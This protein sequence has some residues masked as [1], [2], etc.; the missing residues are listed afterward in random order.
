MAFGGQNPYGPQRQPDG[1]HTVPPVPPQPGAGPYQGGN[2]YQGPGPYQGGNPYQGP[3]P[4]QG[5]DPYRGGS[6]YQ[7]PNP[8]QGGPQPYPGPSPVPYPQLP[9]PYGPYM[10]PPP[11]VWQ[12]FR[13]GD[14]PPLSTLLQRL[15]AH[16]YVLAALVCCALPFFLMFV[17]GYPMARS[18]RLMAHRRFPPF[19]RRVQDPQV[20]RVQKA[21]A[22]CALAASLLILCLYGTEADV[23]ELQEQFMIRLAIT[24]WLLLLTAPVVILVLFRISSPAARP[25]MR[26]GIGPAARSALWFVGATTAVPLLFMGAVFI[27]VQLQD[28][29]PPALFT[30]ATFVPALWMVLFVGFASVSVV[31]TVFGTSEMHAALPALLTGLLVWELTAVNLL[32]GMPPGPPLVQI[33]AVVCGPASVSAVAWWELRRLRTRFGVRLRA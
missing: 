25:R 21:R 9:V 17:I 33:A 20:T 23:E 6:P 19:H 31:R 28:A 26:A 4:Y 22:W 14:W 11:S 7:G 2:P 27:G 30:L 18:A 13:A 1:G 16:W 8:Y 29:D 12:R 15:G 32:S 3:G 10:P 24:P 5:P